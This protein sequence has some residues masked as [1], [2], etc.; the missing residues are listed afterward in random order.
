M[1]HGEAFFLIAPEIPLDGF[2]IAL[3]LKIN[4]KGQKN[5]VTLPQTVW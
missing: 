5:H 4:T 1:P 2:Y 3:L